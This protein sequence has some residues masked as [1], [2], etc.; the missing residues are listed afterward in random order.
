METPPLHT[1]KTIV[2]PKLLNI[3]IHILPKVAVSVSKL[4][5]YR[6]GSVYFTKNSSYKSLKNRSYVIVFGSY[7]ATLTVGKPL[8]DVSGSANHDFQTSVTGISDEIGASYRKTEKFFS[9][10]LIFCTLFLHFFAP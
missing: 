5:A 3:L 6:K 8:G 9:E 2:W 7:S 4:T 1:G 10:V